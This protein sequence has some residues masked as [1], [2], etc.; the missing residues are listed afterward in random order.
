MEEKL[1]FAEISALVVDSDRFSSNIINQILRGFGLRRHLIVESGE[2]AQKL[3]S[4]GGF[5]LLLTECKL[6]DMSG[7]DLIH[8]VRHN[9]DDKLRHITILLLTGYTQF[10]SVIGAR[11]VG[12]NSVV[13]KPVS[14]HVLFD[15]VAWAA[16]TERP[17][18]EADEYYGPCRRFHFDEAPP[19][20]SRRASDHYA[21]PA[22]TRSPEAQATEEA[23]S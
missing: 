8:W 12:V 23:R 15:H 14:P 6:P 7:A 2:A 17:F 21:G 4:N 22:I 19:G 5:E 11:D 10:S 20:Q 13:R 18:I 3:L 9:T 16:R 1:N